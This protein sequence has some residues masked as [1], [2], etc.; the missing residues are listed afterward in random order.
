[1]I[2]P[3]LESVGDST[4]SGLVYTLRPWQWYKQ[5]ILYIP[6]VFSGSALELTAWIN[7]TLGVVL[8]SG[9]AG[10]TYIINDLR[11]RE[12]DRQH[13]RK[14]HRPIPSGQVSVWLAVVWALVLYV[15]VAY[16]S[17]QLNQAFLVIIG[18]YVAQNFL[19]STILKQY[20]FADLFSISAGFVLRALAG[21]VLT[22]SDMSPWLILSMFLAAMMFGVSKRWG[23]YQEVDNP[24]AIRSSL[25]GYSPEILKLLLGSVATMLLMTYALYTFFARDLLMML[26]IPFAFYAVFRYVYLTVGVKGDSEP[27]K[28]ILDRPLLTNFALWGLTLSAILYYPQLGVTL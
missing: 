25:E 18:V 9:A 6:V 17:W 28:L 26:T 5:L 27:V 19:Y 23:E 3:D 20:M 8:F 15:G 24:A 1:M 12:Q 14:Q 2:A 21:V 10:G 22:A 11:D 7:T 16:L 13:P 4:L